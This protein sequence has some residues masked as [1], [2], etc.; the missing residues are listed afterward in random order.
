MTGRVGPLHSAGRRTRSSPLFFV[1]SFY[2]EVVVRMDAGR[3]DWRLPPVLEGADAVERMHGIVL[4]MFTRC[5]ACLLGMEV[6]GAGA[7]DLDVARSDGA[8]VDEALAGLDRW[9]AR[10]ASADAVHVGPPSG[11]DALPDVSS[12]TVDIS[13]STWWNEAPGR[14]VFFDGDR[15]LLPVD[16]RTRIRTDGGSVPMGLLMFQ[17]PDAYIHGFDAMRPIIGYVR[18]NSGVL[19]G[20]RFEFVESVARRDRGC[21][22]DAVMAVVARGPYAVV[23]PDDAAGASRIIRALRAEPDEWSAMLGDRRRYRGADVSGVLQH[24]VI[25]VLPMPFIRSIA[26]SEARDAID[27]GLER[28]SCFDYYSARPASAAAYMADRVYESGLADGLRRMMPDD[29][30]IDAR[31]LSMLID[32]YTG[33]R[34]LDDAARIAGGAIGTMNLSAYD[35]APVSADFDAVTDELVRALAD[36]TLHVPGNGESGAFPPE[37]VREDV[38]DVLDGLE[39]VRWLKAAALGHVRAV[40]AGERVARRI[41]DLLSG[42]CSTPEIRSVV[43]AWTDA[44]TPE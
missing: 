25:G 43:A 27:S 44:P 30:D 11:V 7:H 12:V 3:D 18:D 10:P 22:W 36:G 42:P 19:S 40:D 34:T 28:P 35:D 16:V 21:G 41:T 13:Y 39:S 31:W 20:D 1:C 9:E 4:D 2:G 26:M 24:P 29:S 23:M 15:L 33:L 38:M 8:R 37:M 6:M 17:S 14:R 32:G 5:H